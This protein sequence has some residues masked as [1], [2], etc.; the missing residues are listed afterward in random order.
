MYNHLNHKEYLMAYTDDPEVFNRAYDL[1]RKGDFQ[2]AYDL[3]TEAVPSYPENAQRLYEWRFDIAARMGKFE[4]AEDL[5]REALDAGCF[6]SEF[7]LRKDDDLR[8]MQGRRRFE[9]LVERNFKLLAQ[10][11]QSSRPELDLINP[12]RVQDD[13][14]M[15]LLMALHGN[16]SNV[17]RFRGYWNSLIG[18]DWLVVLPQSSQV[19]GKGI[20]VWNN[21]EFTKRELIDH[22]QA[23]TGDYP[24]D[25]IRSLVAGFSKGG[26]AAILAALDEW[27]PASGFI[28]LAPYIPDV[29]EMLRL[30]DKAKRRLPRGYF[31]LGGEDESCT[32]GA[33]KLYEG[34]EKRGMDCRLK[35]FPGVEHDFPPDFGQILPQVIDFLTRKESTWQKNP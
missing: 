32:P 1:Y 25:P 10:A 23:I 29:D 14:T 33:I 3:L 9:H 4:L 7:T 20:Y 24:A 31:L 12:G 16:N 2:Q 35:V 22:Y 26:H 19:G 34:M 28:A 8:E 17:E 27:I 18:S 13:G 30:V 11:Q 21:L 15:P 6:Y 5:L